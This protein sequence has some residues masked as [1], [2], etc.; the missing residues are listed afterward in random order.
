[1]HGDVLG[2]ATEEGELL[3][4]KVGIEASPGHLLRQA[5]QAAT[6]TPL[7][8]RGR[9]LCQAYGTN[10]FKDIYPPS[11]R[12]FLRDSDMSMMTSV[13]STSRIR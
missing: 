1:M 2:A 10:G 9:R 5:H 12:T 6:E 8:G 11:A 3:G 13:P 4:D 7:S